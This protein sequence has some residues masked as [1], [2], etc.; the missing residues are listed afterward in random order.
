MFVAMTTLLQWLASCI[1]G[2]I[3]QAR[4]SNLTDGAADVAAHCGASPASASSMLSTGSQSM[5]SQPLSCTTGNVV[6]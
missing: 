4:M 1:H 2:D 5:P 3:P 6:S